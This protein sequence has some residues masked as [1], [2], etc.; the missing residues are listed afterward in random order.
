MP[1]YLRLLD[2]AHANDPEVAT[3]WATVVA[4]E[5][6]ATAVRTFTDVTSLWTEAETRFQTAAKLSPKSALVFT[7][8][9]LNWLNLADWNG[10]TK[11]AD[12][13]GMW[14]HAAE[15]S[16]MAVA[17]EPTNNAA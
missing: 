3:L 4:N 1:G 12:P 9:G 2:E 16:E 11:A 13:Q 17:L 8:W 15:K 6:H 14:A 10:W 5:A 7:R